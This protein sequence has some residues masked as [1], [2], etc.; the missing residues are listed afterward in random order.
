MPIIT[1]S[2]VTGVEMSCSIVP[3]SHSRETVSEVSCAPT[4][5]RITATTPGM[6]KLRLSRPSLNQTRGSRSTIA[7]PGR[8]ECRAPAAHARFEIGRCLRDHSLRVADGDVGRVGIGRIEHRLHRGAPVVV[9]AAREIDR[10]GD[11]AYAGA[12]VHGLAHRPLVAQTYALAE[13]QPEATKRC[14][15]SRLVWLC[16]WS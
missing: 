4:R 2:A 11:R 16:S 9:S 15:S 8:P 3:R 13:N 10:N 7:D 14:T 5:P 12:A 1:S 6:M